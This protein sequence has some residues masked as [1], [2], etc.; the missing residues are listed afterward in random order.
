MAGRKNRTKRWRRRGRFGGL[1]K[2][3]SFL[4]IFAALL[5]GCVVF[6]RVN[7]IRVEGNSRYTVEEII[8][9]SGVEIGDNL[10]LV[11]R[12]QTANAIMKRLPYVESATPVHVLPDTVELRVTESRAVAAVEAEG[13]WWLINAGGKLLE[14]GDSSIAAGYPK[15][16]GFSPTEPSVGVRMAAPIEEQNHLEGLRGLLTALSDRGM[17]GNVRQFIDLGSNNV[18]RFDYGDDLTVV[19]PASGD[20]SRRIFSLQRVLETFA[21]RGERVTGTLDLTYGESEA[22]L[23]TDRWLPEN[24][25]LSEA[26]TPGPEESVQVPDTAQ[27]AMPESTL[28]PPEEPSIAGE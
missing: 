6:F 17:M 15:V 22:R 4:V 14:Q 23:L 8:A 10:F 5:V 7:E 11:N 18:I 21:Q 26:P 2:L 13:N 3:L 9:A 12:P 24:F 20:F 25:I 19:I 16:L 27:P 1:Y 28:P